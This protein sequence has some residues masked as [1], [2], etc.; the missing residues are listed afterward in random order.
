MIKFRHIVRAKLMSDCQTGYR[1]LQDGVEIGLV[2]Q[3]ILPPF[4]LLSPNRT[5]WAGH[6]KQ[7]QCLGRFRTRKE[8]TDQII[9]NLRQERIP[10]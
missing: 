7:G 3:E 4:R 1:V 2:Y 6:N 10:V 8:A 9:I 5:T